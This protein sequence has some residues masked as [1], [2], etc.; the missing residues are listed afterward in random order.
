MILEAATLFRTRGTLG[1]LQRMIEILTDSQVVIIEH[2]RL[3]GGGVFGN[4]ASIESQSVLGAGYRVGGM[5][6]E[7][8]KLPIED[9]QPVDFDDF[10]HRFT[11]TVVAALNEQ[12]LACVRRLVEYH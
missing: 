8:G 11:V 6:G 12:Q 1:S 7:P 9:A 10:A 2:F 5:I 3:R 4:P